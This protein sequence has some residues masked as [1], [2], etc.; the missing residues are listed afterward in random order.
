MNNKYQDLMS[1]MTPEMMEMIQVL[2]LQMANTNLA[3]QS[4]VVAPKPKKPNQ[5]ITK[6]YLRDKYSD[7]T[8]TVM[9]VTNG[10][11][12]YKS[13]KGGYPY[14]WS[15]YG[16]TD[17]LSIEDLLI[18]PQKYLTAP[19][20]MILDDSGEVVE[21]LGL[22]KYYQHIHLL[23]EIESIEEFDDE[24]MEEL[25]QAVQ[26]FAPTKSRE[27]VNKIACRIQEKIDNGTLDS[28]RKI[29][30]LEKILGKEFVQPNKL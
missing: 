15:G 24:K 12:T 5:P 26:V 16:D 25:K 10:S 27:F 9:N 14:V 7:Q 1:N 17:E 18:M 28:N 30:Q 8:I 13:P 20:L 3:N 11:V 22:Q 29:M 21:G 2:A 6:K 4:Q 19:W 23:D